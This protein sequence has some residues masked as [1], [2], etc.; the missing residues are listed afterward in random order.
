MLQGK[1]GWLIEQ[2]SAGNQIAKAYIKHLEGVH[3]QN[4]GENPPPDN[5]WMIQYGYDGSPVFQ[6]AEME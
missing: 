1:N 2:A 5:D 4:G 3:M 6:Q